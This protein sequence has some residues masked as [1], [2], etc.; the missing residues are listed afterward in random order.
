MNGRLQTVGRVRG[1]NKQ[2]TIGRHI[3]VCFMPRLR[4]GGFGGFMLGVVGRI[5]KLSAHL[6]K[7]AELCGWLGRGG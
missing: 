1:L 5:W 4:W 2:A 7:Q 6:V 3:G